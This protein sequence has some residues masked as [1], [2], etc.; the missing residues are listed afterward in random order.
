MQAEFTPSRGWSGSVL[1]NGVVPQ[2][3]S[4]TFMEPG[5]FPYHC[6]FHTSFGMVGT[7]I[8]MPASTGGGGGGNSSTNKIEDPIPAKISKGG[9]AIDLQTLAEGL[10]APLGIVTPD[11][12]SGRTFVYDQTGLVEL[13]GQGTTPQHLFWMS[14]TAW[15]RSGL[16]T[17]SAAFWAWRFTLISPS[18]RCFTHTP[19]SPTGA[20]A[21][22]PIAMPAGYDQRSPGR[23]RRM[24][25]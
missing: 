20:T 19:V 24:A 22:F 7:V 9:L 14:A 3:C 15:R 23:D 21:D 13:L 1:W 11:D 5:T 25:R 12:Q 2:T 4:R 8:V 10:T 18:T 17:M 6:I 16:P